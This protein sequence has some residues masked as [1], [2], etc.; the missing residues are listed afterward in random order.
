M[1]TP[2][3]SLVLSGGGLKGLAHIGVLRAL[4]ERGMV[5]TAVVG[6]SMGSLIAAA[7]AAEVPIEEMEDR[8]LAVRRKDVFRVAHVDMALK[9]MLAPAVY[10]R[11]PL[12]ALIHSLVGD[13][14]FAQLARRLIVN[15]ADLETGQQVLWGLPGLDDAPVA[16]AVFASC[17]LP[18]LLPPRTVLGRVCVDGAV[19]ENL[20]VR[21][22]LAAVRAPV[23]AVDVSGQGAV[24]RGVGRT[25]FAAIYSRGLEIVMQSLISA[26]L[27]EWSAVPLVLIRPRL[28]RLSMFVF[29]RT[30]Y[31][32]AEGYRATHEAL[33]ALPTTLDALP[34]AIYPERRL[35]LRIDAPACVSCGIC[36]SRAPE[37]F[38]WGPEGRA[39]VSVP[40][41]RWSP[42]AEEMVRACP[43]GAIHAEAV[44]EQG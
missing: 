4:A 14:T 31:L 9:R 6:C 15:T 7:W 5:P 29:N 39:V 32:I 43:T 44:P 38:A 25:G 19:V 34:V 26:T 30:P 8:A 27:R 10:R 24:R 1:T 13:R 20:P 16:D 40:F 35:H 12:D 33:D 42:L 2:A 37:V 17:S 21:A 18:G 22:G 11:E 3:F 28:E 23:I 36:V 41:Q